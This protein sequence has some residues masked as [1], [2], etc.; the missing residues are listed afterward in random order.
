M[1]EKIHQ[2]KSNPD[3]VYAEVMRMVIVEN[4]KTKGLGI[5]AKVLGELLELIK[6]IAIER[7]ITHLYLQSTEESQQIY[8]RIGFKQIGRYR[9]FEGVS[10][11]CPM[12]LNIKN[13]NGEIFRRV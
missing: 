8:E 12:I 1:A 11:E 9:M 3:N 10:N 2:L 6:E 4:H 13:I 7:S 5:K